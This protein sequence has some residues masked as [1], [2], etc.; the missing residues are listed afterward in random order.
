MTGLNAGVQGGMTGKKANAWTAAGDAA[1][2]ART[3]DSKAKSGWLN[4]IQKSATQAQLSRSARKL[5]LTD[6]T[7]ASA[8]QNMIDMQGLAS[9]AQRKW[10]Y[11]LQSGHFY[12]FDGNEITVNTGKT[13]IALCP[14]DDFPF[15]GISAE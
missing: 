5:N 8:K 13:Y 10:E 14:D 1:L 9:E 3:G 15:V 11:G 7:L 12:D 2:Q 6:E 4:A